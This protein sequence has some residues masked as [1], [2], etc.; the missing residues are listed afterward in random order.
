MLKGP[1]K[2]PA[3]ASKPKPPARVAKKAPPPPQIK[4]PTRYDLEFGFDK[5]RVNLAMGRKLDSIIA[6][7]K[8]KSVTFKVIGHA[9]MMGLGRY[10]Q[11]LSADRANAVKRAMIDRGVSATQITANGVGQAKLAVP[12]PKGKRL[13]ANRR[14]VI[15]VERKM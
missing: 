4:M 11:K 6:D 7:W 9:D 5:S 10:N 15:T 12:T 13:R 1:R 3:V 14:V 2:P 8:G